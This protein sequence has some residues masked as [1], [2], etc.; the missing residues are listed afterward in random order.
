MKTRYKCDPQK[1]VN[2]PKTVCQKLCFATTK[3]EFAV[4]GAEPLPS[5]DF[6]KKDSAVQE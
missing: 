1:N 5:F 2:C 4:D 6:E 3:K